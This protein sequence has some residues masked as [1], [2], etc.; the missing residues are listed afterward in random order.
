MPEFNVYV[1]EPAFEKA[2]G[3]FRREAGKNLEAM[4]LLVG[5]VFENGFVLITDY[6]TAE[7]EASAVSV[8]FRENAF[9]E[10]TRLLSEKGSEGFVVGWA[11]SH[12][13]YGCFMSSTDAGTQRSFFNNEHNVALVIDPAKDEARF[14]R[15]NN[16]ECVEISFAV[17]RRK[18]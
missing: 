16:G 4:G 1:E 5:E 7:N 3:H 12:P 11:H 8:R 17:V 14:F 9:S 10:L 18:Q 2:R 6:V 15:L 13:G